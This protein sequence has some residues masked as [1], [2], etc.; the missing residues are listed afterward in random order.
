MMC[1]AQDGEGGRLM[2]EGRSEPIASRTLDGVC[3]I[4]DAV[5]HIHIRFYKVLKTE[6]M[7]TILVSAPCAEH[8][9]PN[10][11]LQETSQSTELRRI[12]QRR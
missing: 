2:I 1:R 6:S 7:D 4:E 12:S 5:V 10:A 11:I 9:P 8:C 3:V